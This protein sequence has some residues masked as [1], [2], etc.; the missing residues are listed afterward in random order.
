MHF[1]WQPTEA[2]VH[3]FKHINTASFLSKTSELFNS[4]HKPNSGAFNV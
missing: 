1:M 3:A 4:H 2:N